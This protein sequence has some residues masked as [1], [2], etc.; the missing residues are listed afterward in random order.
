MINRLLY[1]SVILGVM[2]SFIIAPATFAQED[3][4]DVNELLLHQVE[5]GIELADFPHL[6]QDDLDAA[7]D[8]LYR[9]GIAYQALAMGCGFDR[10]HEIADEHEAEHGEADE[11][12][13][14]DEHDD[15]E[16][17][18]MDGEMGDEAV[19]AAI[20]AAR[21]M[22]DAENGE[23]LFNTLQP[24]TGFACATCHLV[25]TT[26]QLVGPGL[27]GVG[28]PMHDPSA[29]GDA[30]EADEHDE[31]AEADEHD[32]AAEGD[33]HDDEADEHDDD[34]GEMM[35]DGEMAMMD[36]DEM[37]AMMAGRGDNPV[38]Y[39]RTSILDPNAYVAAGFPENLM[40][41]V[42]A[43]VFSEQEIND[44]IAYLLTL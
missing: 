2:A 14:T 35:D 5:H 4:C 8:A 41:Q 18:M 15:G 30:A 7:L 1:V 39:I 36:D 22:G 6:A 29:H 20:A 40:P 33:D 9:T 44:L 13:D 43:E 12:A 24:A 21:E 38:E 37:A 3:E 23:V 32:E 42:Y 26:D 34:D 27:L 11:H 17:A 19:T 28:D 25:N 16:M 31:A 10:T